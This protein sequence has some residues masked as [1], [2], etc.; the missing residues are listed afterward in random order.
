VVV[1]GAAAAY[2]NDTFVALGAGGLVPVKANQIVM[3]SEELLISTH[4]ISIQYVFANPTDKDIVAT[5]AFPLPELAGGDVEN[6]PLSL[7]SEADLNFVQ[8]A[9][10][11]EGKA[12]PVRVEYRAYAQGREITS[13]L[14]AAGLAPNVLLEPLNAS[15]LKVPESNRRDL[16]K[17]ELIVP[18]EFNPPLHSVGSHGWW[19][20]WSM[21]VQY[22][23]T[24]R[25]PAH[26]TMK[27]T[28]RYKP[29]VGG[30][31]IVGSDDGRNSVRP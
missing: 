24:Q 12:V 5:V 11:D 21:R 30:S 13:R 9:V 15:L 8:F 31:Y 3:Q 14:R 23:W 4:Q 16:E 17:A 25:F 22:Y 2:P 6:E 10:E 29:I 27:L 1:L 26:S 28:Q 18:S 7:P 19:A 20:T